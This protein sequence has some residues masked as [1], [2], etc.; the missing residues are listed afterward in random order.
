MGDTVLQ[1]LSLCCSARDDRAQHVQEG[2]GVLAPNEHVRL[3]SGS[4]NYHLIS[5]IVKYLRF[6]FDWFEPTW[7]WN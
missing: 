1:L 7:F 3:R 6:C 2:V 4:R 5:R